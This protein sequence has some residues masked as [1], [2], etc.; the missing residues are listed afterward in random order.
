MCIVCCNYYYYYYCRWLA[1]LATR[2]QHLILIMKSV[3]KA[4]CIVSYFDRCELVTILCGL[5]CCMLSAY[6]FIHIAQTWTY[7]LYSNVYELLYWLPC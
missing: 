6:D 5:T 2:M 4:Y 1:R 3:M 7:I